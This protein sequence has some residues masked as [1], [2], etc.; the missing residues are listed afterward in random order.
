MSCQRALSTDKV[1]SAHG[2]FGP[3]N[4]ESIIVRDRP[5][6]LVTSALEHS[7]FGP[8]DCVANT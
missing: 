8:N 3:G 4:S 6:T 2:E 7:D 1:M 5:A